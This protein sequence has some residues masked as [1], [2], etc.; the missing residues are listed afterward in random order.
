MPCQGAHD[1]GVLLA[2][3]VR[4]SSIATSHGIVPMAEPSWCIRHCTPV[5]C[6]GIMGVSQLLYNAPLGHGFF[7]WLIA[8]GLGTLVP[9]R[10]GDRSH[11]A[12]CRYG[13]KVHTTHV[14]EP[15]CACLS[16]IRV[17]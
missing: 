16:S 3:F 12:L 13:H 2:S 9:A 14:V 5:L 8:Q 4:S 7:S 17:S 11:Q 15:M 10:G 6:E 1:L